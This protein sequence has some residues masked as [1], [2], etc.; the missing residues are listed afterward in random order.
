MGIGTKIYFVEKN[1]VYRVGLDTKKV[2]PALAGTMVPY[3]SVI[4]DKDDSKKITN[5][6]IDPAYINCDGQ[7]KVSEFEHR[8]MQTILDEEFSS[9]LPEV[10]KKN[11]KVTSMKYKPKPI[12]LTDKQKELVKERIKKDFGDDAWGK[13]PGWAKANLWKNGRCV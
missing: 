13:L 1:R 10:S 11:E 2:F 3:V 6:R 12:K 8:Q 5:I 7:W 4:Y 9:I